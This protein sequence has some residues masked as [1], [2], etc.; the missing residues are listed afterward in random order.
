MDVIGSRKE[1]NKVINEL[2]TQLIAY[3]QINSENKEKKKK[4][5]RYLSYGYYQ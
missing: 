5:M 4:E 3:S 1:K 2:M